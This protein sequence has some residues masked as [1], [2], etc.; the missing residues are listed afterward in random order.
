M[1]EERPGYDDT[2]R[3]PDSDYRV[4]DPD[5]PHPVSVDPGGTSSATDATPPAD[6]TVLFDGSDLS[7]WDATDGGDPG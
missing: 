7:A 5:R 1:R 3:L 6:A 2:P 4:H